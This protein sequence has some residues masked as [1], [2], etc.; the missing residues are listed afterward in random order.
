[1]RALAIIILFVIATPAHSANVT[2]GKGKRISVN[3]K[4][5]AAFQSLIDWLQENGY[6]IQFARGYGRGTVRQSL[7]PSGMAM[8]INQTGRNRVTRAY[9]PGT[10]EKAASL[11]IFHGSKWPH[12]P[13]YGHFQIGGWQ[14]KHPLIASIETFR[15][16]QMESSA[17]Q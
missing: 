2:F 3:P 12:S 8:D 16:K 11:G 7:H 15:A 4:A 6:K 14:G 1:M 13:D 5:A 9:P 10:T 17:A